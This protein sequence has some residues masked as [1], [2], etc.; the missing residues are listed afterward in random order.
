MAN[1]SNIFVRAWKYMQAALTGKFN[2]MADP[3]IQ[4]EQAI[5]EASDQHRRL[6]EQAANV[7]ANQR[8]T[9][10][11]LERKLDELDKLS[12]NAQQALL[13]AD[14]ARKSGNETKASEFERAAETIATKLISIE[15]EVDDLKD[16]SMKSAQQTAQA[17]TAVDQNSQMLQKKLAE[18]Q[19]L[20]GQIDQAKMAEQMNEAMA[21]LNE[22]VG[23]DAPTFDEVR[24]KVERRLAKA[25]GATELS[26]TGVESRVLE[27]ES[28]QR[29]VEAQT[30]LSELRSKLGLQEPSAATAAPAA[31]ATPDEGT[32]ATA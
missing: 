24:D 14:D 27:I 5:L 20:L 16:L 21:S 18:K 25:Q 10:M 8:Q 13:M 26:S 7:I 28:A 30:R 23:R 17:K 22:T 29:N 6:K 15:S 3:K 11:K 4:L 19:K 32:T 1:R 9:E 2:E 31:T 12:G